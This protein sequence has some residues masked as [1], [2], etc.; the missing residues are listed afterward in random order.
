MENQLYMWSTW[1]VMNLFYLKLPVL[2]LVDALL[3]N[4]NVTIMT[5]G[6]S[7]PW[8]TCPSKM[9]TMM[10]IDDL[11]K[12]KSQWG[13]EMNCVLD[14]SQEAQ[15]IMGW[16]SA[17]S[18]SIVFK[19]FTK[20]E[21][22]KTTSSV[23]GSLLMYTPEMIHCEFI[24]NTW[25]FLLIFSKMPKVTWLHY[26]QYG[27]S[28]VLNMAARSACCPQCHVAMSE[29]VN[30]SKQVPLQNPRT[31][32]CLIIIVGGKNPQVVAHWIYELL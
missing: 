2:G 27:R 11:R 25:Y 18:L 12:V 22:Q 13:I 7:K 26:M 23:T 20:Q 8:I 1:A 4:P 3:Q 19:Y 6:H 14:L 24:W 29:V 10:N 21:P 30:D 9:L 17:L 15:C 32:I 31:C 16:T 28:C 5:W